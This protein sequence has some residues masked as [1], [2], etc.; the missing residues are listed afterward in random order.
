MVYLALGAAGALLG[1]CTAPRYAGRT[2]PAYVPHTRG[3]LA[4]AADFEAMA[5]SGAGALR[6]VK[7]VIRD[8]DRD[9]HARVEFLDAAAYRFHDEWYWLQLLNGR[10]VHGATALVGG[11]GF[12]TAEAAE[13]WFRTA[14][15]GGVDLRVIEGDRLYAPHF[16]Q[17]A[18][19]EPRALGIGSI[20]HLPAQG[21][22]A[23][24]WGFTLEYTDRAEAETVE[25]FMALLQPQ[26]PPE[27][28]GL[29]W[30]TRSPFQAAVAER[31][32]ATRPGWEGRTLAYAALSVP[33]EAVVYNPGVAAGRLRVVEAGQ[34]IVGALGPEDIAVV[35]GLFDDLPPCAGLLSA[36]PHTPLSHLNML[37]ANRGIPSAYVGGLH[38]NAHLMQLAR[39]QAPVMLSAVDGRVRLTPLSAA[40]YA[41]LTDRRVRVLHLSPQGAA[42]DPAELP[43]WVALDGKGALP[44]ARLVGGKA[45]GMARLAAAAAAA[46]VGTTSG[47]PGGS[48][49]PSLPSPRLALTVRAYAQHTAALH[50]ELVPLVDSPAFAHD[51][52]MQ[53]LALEG[54]ERYD[55]LYPGAYDREYARGL[56]ARSRRLQDLVARGGV[57]AIIRDTPFEPALLAELHRNLEARFGALSATQGLR[58]RSSS[59]A[60][61]VD[62]F[63]GAGLYVSSTGYLR[64]GLQAKARDRRRSVA[65]A[66][67]RTWASYWNWQ[68]Y[69]ERQAAGID[70]L[71][72]RMAVLVHP[73]FDDAAELAN[74]VATFHYD[75]RRGRGELTVNAQAGAL[76]VT[77]PP[78]DRPVTPEVARAAG[79]DGATAKVQRLRASSEG[80]GVVVAEDELRVL[81]SQAQAFARHWLQHDNAARPA[82]QRAGTLTLDLELRRMAGAWPA[83]LPGDAP[84]V[85]WKQARSL[86]PVA[87]LP[88]L[89]DLDLPVPIDLARRAEAM[90]QLRCTADDLVVTLW[91]LT[92]PGGVPDFVPMLRV[93]QGSGPT[94]ELT[95]LQFAQPDANGVVR[96]DGP[97][98]G[99]GGPARLD[100]GALACEPAAA[101]L[102]SRAAMLR[103]LEARAIELG[104]EAPTS[105]A[106]K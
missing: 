104:R 42:Q 39:A 5:S 89:E 59:T 86:Q 1:G 76:S 28:A 18:L 71:G 91:R 105:P 56:L 29:R 49:I 4:T 68:A 57:K 38:D 35:G 13:A 45:R 97:A 77:N 84:R 9:G 61:D 65:W 24:T 90:Q 30:V 94:R 74:G 67:R 34:S 81:F 33:G 23:G 16:Y 14:P 7:F 60:E 40:E 37:A 46:A 20:V 54:R 82:P 66:L 78:T 101:P 62:G 31:M 10:A 85:V 96:L 102:L 72:G 22:R 15:P 11:P 92:L 3:A 50:A 36:I 79:S 21:S 41:Q 75:A 64:P 26:L 19:S 98:T 8:F 32:R 53:V 106:R 87:A 63:S 73:R 51:R 17:L 103:R 95:H 58:F 2:H 69:A 55:S 93:R 43:L 48:V 83:G 47:D 88:E 12:A 27:A 6:S 70:H 44:D 100:L 80:A 52:R 25:R 99:E